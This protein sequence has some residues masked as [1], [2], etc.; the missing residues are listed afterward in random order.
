LRFRSAGLVGLNYEISYCTAELEVRAA[1]LLAQLGIKPETS[2]KDG[3]SPT[4]LAATV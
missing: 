3:V 4:E 1:E 2:A